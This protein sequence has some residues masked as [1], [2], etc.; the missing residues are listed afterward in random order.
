MT[1]SVKTA[2]RYASMMTTRVAN[3]PNWKL[4]KKVDREL[5]AEAQRMIA[6]GK[7]YKVATAEEMG[8]KYYD[9][10]KHIWAMDTITNM[11]GKVSVNWVMIR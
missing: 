11:S 9:D 5:K 7:A 2:M 1:V 6:A 4:R 8:A 10:N 3:T